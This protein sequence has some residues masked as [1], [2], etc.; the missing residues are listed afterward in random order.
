M[1]Y[2]VS[3]IKYNYN[4]T[5]RCNGR[6]NLCDVVATVVFLYTVKA[7]NSLWLLHRHDIM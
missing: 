4:M 3:Q 5:L 6:S 1:C 2:N 7:P